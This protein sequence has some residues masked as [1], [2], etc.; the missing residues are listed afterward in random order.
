MVGFWVGVVGFW[1]VGICLE[2]ENEDE[3][4]GREGEG[5]ER[6]GFM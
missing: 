1:W 3:D 4:V 6:V 2:D 5:G